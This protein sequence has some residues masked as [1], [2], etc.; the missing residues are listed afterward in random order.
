MAIDSRVRARLRS[1]AQA[2]EETLE[3]GKG[4]VT[5]AL[6]T[7]LKAQLVRRRLVKVGLRPSA[8]HESGRETVAAEIAAKTGSELVEVRG[9]TAVYWK[10]GS[11]PRR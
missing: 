7:E 3:V 10:P 9:N 6:I 1:E 11:L 4:G 2:I 8:T 5:D